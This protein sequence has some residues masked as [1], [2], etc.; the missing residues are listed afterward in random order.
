MA[1]GLSAGARHGLLVKGGAALEAIGGA[2]T[3]AFDKTGT[4]TAGHPRVTDVRPAEGVRET[5]VIRLAAG[6]EPGS[7]HPLA[8]AILAEAAARERPASR[9]RRRRARCPARR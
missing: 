1:S 8:R 3:V 5:E 4:I 9:P 6:V 7:S 2:R